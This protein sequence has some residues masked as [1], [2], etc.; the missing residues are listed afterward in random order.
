MLLIVSKLYVC[1]PIKKSTEKALLAVFAN[2]GKF[3][4]KSKRKSLNCFNM[5]IKKP[6]RLAAEWLRTNKIVVN[7]NEKSNKERK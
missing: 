1:W 3:L 5:F 2:V 6:L 4:N 7:P